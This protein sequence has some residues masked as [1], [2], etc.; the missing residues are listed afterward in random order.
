MGNIIGYF[1][2]SF[3][4][5]Y[6]E[7]NNNNCETA[8]MNI[9][10]QLR[11]SMIIIL[12]SSVL[13]SIT[14]VPSFNNKAFAQ[15]SQSQLSQ[16]A[17]IFKNVMVDTNL[18]PN[19]PFKINATVSVSDIQRRHVLLSLASPDQISIT[20][21][22]IMDLGDISSGNGERMATWTLVAAKSGS[23]PLNLTAYSSSAGIGSIANNFQS[24]SFLFDVSIGA[25]KSL[26]VSKVNVPG[27][28][29]PN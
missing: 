17:V 8:N 9:R 28:L 23:F 1:L 27:N 7:I 5:I 11:Y 14:V 25:L 26:I 16:S 2:I 20:G 24:N 6:Y 4:Y 15:S 18:E 12:I 19:K 13:F 3:Y 22:G 10:D 21:P 29:L